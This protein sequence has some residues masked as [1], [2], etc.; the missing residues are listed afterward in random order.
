MKDNANERLPLVDEN[1]QQIGVA[2]RGYCHCGSKALHPVVHLHVFNA[3]GELF[4]QHRPAWKD[5][6]PD[7]WDT[8]VGGHIDLGEDVET[9]L[10]REAREELGLTDFQAEFRSL[11]KQFRPRTRIGSCVPHHYRRSASTHCRTRRGPLFQPHGNF[12]QT[13]N[14]IFHTELRSGMATVVRQRINAKKS[15]P[16]VIDETHG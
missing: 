13:A 9:A 3:Q 16:R 1:G 2:T 15:Y 5:I 8:A 14:A 6:Q 4:L 7:R 10:R 12:E 11:H